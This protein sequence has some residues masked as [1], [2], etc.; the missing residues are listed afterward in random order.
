MLS[1]RSF[2]SLSAAAAAALAVKPRSLWARPGAANG[3]AKLTLHEASALV[4]RREVS[5]V[6]LTKACLARIEQYESKINAFIT[7]TSKQ[8]LEQAR[9]A[10]AE[11]MVGRWRGPLHG[12]PIALKDNIDTAGIRTTAASAVFVDRIPTEDA[13]VVKRLKQ[14]GAVLLGKLNMTE[15]GSD[16]SSI[17]S[18]WGPIHNP[19]A[20]DHE[21]GGSSGGSAAALAAD[22]CF[23]T[24]GTDTGGSIRVPASFCGVAGF[25]P[26]YGRVSNRGVIPLA[27]SL[28]HVG[29]MGKT[30][31]DTALLLQGI[32]GYDEN[33]VG[34]APIDVPD[35]TAA[36]RGDFEPPRV[37]IA[38]V[39]FFEQLDPQVTRPVDDAL[40]TLKTMATIA[41]DDVVVP[42]VG[43]YFDLVAPELCAYHA[44]LFKQAA[45]LYQP[46]LRKTLTSAL[47]DKPP[48][49]VAYVN[50][51]RA[52]QEVRRHAADIFNDSLDLLV[53][54]T[55]KQLPLSIDARRE[56]S[57]SSQDIL[58]QLFNT[59]PFNVLGLPAISIPCGFTTAGLPIGLQIVGR[60]FAEAQVLALAHAYE[61]KTRWHSYAPR[62]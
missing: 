33:W 31:L 22:F 4:Q 30:A 43:L 52:L 32:A 51:R 48:S 45:A 58:P 7:L 2:V 47:Q 8:A 35:Y 18:Y 1:R 36:L 13:E 23:G 12:I 49:A 46:P 20:L 3:L 28:D 6:E 44:S 41:K 34:S 37:G 11:I 9:V 55:W 57:K 40:A 59:I 17:N 42:N 5:P 24:L 10:E 15:F 53:M 26:S 60:P 27:E 14:A 21:A 39:S 16:V 25:K 50:A 56:Q 61:R 29:P 38:R 62:L 54:P 19:W